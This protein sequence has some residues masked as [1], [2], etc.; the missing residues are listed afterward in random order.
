VLVTVLGG[1]LALFGFV[2]IAEELGEATGELRQVAPKAQ[3]SGVSR[4]CIDR[5]GFWKRRRTSQ[6]LAAAPCCLPVTL[7]AIGYLALEGNMA[8]CGWYQ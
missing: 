2:K 7:F 1:L 4:T 6:P 3:S 8:R 5:R